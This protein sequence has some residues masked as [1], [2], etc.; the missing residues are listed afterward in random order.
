MTR[1]CCHV[2]Q[3]DHRTLGLSRPYLR[4]YAADKPALSYNLCGGPPGQRAAPQ[5]LPVRNG[6]EGLGPTLALGKPT[7]EIDTLRLGSLAMDWGWKRLAQTI[8]HTEVPRSNYRHE[9]FP[10]QGRLRPG[11]PC[12]AA[13]Q[14]T[15]ESTAPTGWSMLGLTRPPRAQLMRRSRSQCN[16]LF[17]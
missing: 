2:V 8:V 5:R 17:L 10:D 13:L 12:T 14:R 6:T 16:Y 11:E 3:S 15:P 1:R 4:L 7:A 9:A